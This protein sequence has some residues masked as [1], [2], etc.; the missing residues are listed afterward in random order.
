MTSIKYVMI[1]MSILMSSCFNKKKKNHRETKNGSSLNT[2]TI[3]LSRNISEDRMSGGSKRETAYFIVSGADTSDF[4]IVFSESEEDGKIWMRIPDNDY[5]I[6][7]KTYINRMNEIKKVLP[8][9][10]TD[11]NPD[12]LN[13]IYMGRLV[14]YGD[15]AIQVTNEYIAKFG[16]KYKIVD[17]DYKKIA[18]F[19]LESTLAKDLNQLFEPYSLRVKE[20]YIEKTF[21]MSTGG[22]F[23]SSSKIKTDHLE[24]PDEILDCIVSL[25]LEKKIK[26]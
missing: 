7:E 8:K 21:F 25:T 18:G 16:K 22:N 6:R 1:L 19:L 2:D 20:I 9:A 11:Y 24:I 26:Q 13:S 23:P 10:K 17:S 4:R 14:S 15:L 12:S 5:D 3:V